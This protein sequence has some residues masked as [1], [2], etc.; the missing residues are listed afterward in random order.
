MGTVS[1][2]QSVISGDGAY[3]AFVSH[4]TDLVPG[5]NGPSTSNVYVWERASGTTTLVSESVSAAGQRGNN[6]SGEPVIS[7]DGATVAF[8]ELATDLVP[9]GSGP[10]AYNVYVWERSSGTTTLVSESV[11][12]AGQRGNGYSYQP[13]IS[14]DGAYVA[15]YGRATD[16]VPG[17]SGPSTWNV[18]VW[19]R[20]SGTTTLVSESVSAAGQRGN[21][22]SYQPV[23]SGDGAYVAF[24][25]PATDLVAGGSGPSTENVYVW[26][27]S[28]GTTTLV[29]ESVSAAGQRGNNLSQQPVISGD[30][31]TVAFY[32]TA[33]DLVSGGSGPWLRTCT[34]GSARR[35]RRRWC[36][37]RCWRPVGA[38]TPPPPFR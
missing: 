9:G 19:E 18:Y 35:G 16:L 32:G 33:T 28:S 12:A 26:E 24:Q 7:G 11:S 15:F 29:S 2:D 31:A 20:S 8:S 13:V 22:I 25:S 4:A 36:R 3:V 30:G 14:G 38:G 1:S 17:G 6:G 10:S 23:I 5:G 37:S 27:R 34:C 21:G